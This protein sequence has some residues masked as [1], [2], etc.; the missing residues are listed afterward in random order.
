[1]KFHLWFTDFPPLTHTAARRLLSRGEFSLDIP[2]FMSTG[3][4]KARFLLKSGE[5]I[6]LSLQEASEE[7][8]ASCSACRSREEILCTHA[9]GAVLALREHLTKNGPLQS[10]PERSPG[11]ISRSPS[12]RDPDPTALL[13]CTELVLAGSKHSPAF[14]VLTS[15]KKPLDP[16]SFR[17]LESIERTRPGTLSKTASLFIA[18]FEPC[19]ITEK[20]GRTIPAYRP[21]KT[22][23]GKI[24]QYFALPGIRIYSTKSHTP[25][26][27]GFLAN[28]PL[29]ELTARWVNEP[30]GD[31]FLEGWLALGTE[32][33]FLKDTLWID[34]DGCSA[35]CGQGT[36]LFFEQDTRLPSSLKRLMDR[37]MEGRPLSAGEW[38]PLLDPLGGN[39]DH[40]RFLSF[41]PSSAS[42][43]FGA[44]QAWTPVVVVRGCQDG[45]L[46]LIPAM[47]FSGQ[48][49]VP[50]FGAARHRLGDYLRKPTDSLAPTLFLI[51]RD[52]EREL[53]FRSL[54]EKI[55]RMSSTEESIQ[56]DKG[57]AGLVLDQLLPALESSGFGID[58]SG[59]FDGSIL[60]GPVAVRLSVSALSRELLRVQGTLDT[61]GGRF[62]L[63]P[64]PRKES[65]S[66]PEDSLISVNS[67]KS[68]YLEG[69]A[70]E[71]FREIHQ[72]FS[73]E[74]DGSASVSRFY[75]AMLK[76][77]R[78][79]LPIIP[80][81]GLEGKLAPFVPV[82]IPPALFDRLSTVFGATLRPYQREALSFLHSLW[83]EGL[84]GILAD[85]MGLGKTISVLGFLMLMKMENAFPP[86]TRPPLIALPASLLYNW[87]HEAN[88]FC[89][90]VRLHVHA[91]TGRM[92]RLS[93]SENSDLILTTYGTLRNDPHLAE[94]FPFSCLVL[95]E[96]HLVKNPDSRTHQ[97]IRSLPALR[98]IA[99]TG[100]PVENRISD[101]WGIFDITMPNFLGSRL[102]FEKRFFREN[103]GESERDSRISLLR[104]LVSPLILRRTKEMV[105][106]DL[107]PKVEVDIW[108]DPSPEERS[109]YARIKSRGTE[110]ILSSKHLEGPLRMAYLTLLL[111]LRQLACHPDLLPPEIRGDLNHSSKFDLVLDKITE[112][113]EE[114][115]KILLFSQFTSILDLFEN[116]LPA[117]GISSVRLDG[118]TPLPERQK[119]VA[120]FQSDSP[121]SPS[122]F[123]ASL[124]AGG[125][126][127]TL[128]RADYVFH[129]DP[130]WNPQV[131][132]QASDRSHRLGQDRKVFVY[133]FLVRGTVEE[134][135]QSLKESK[136]EIFNLLMNDSPGETP[137]E[138]GIGGLSI[139]DMKGLLDFAPDT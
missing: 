13:P 53:Y 5:I 87:V 136:K 19:R 98:R 48:I 32:K 129:Y 22:R 50:L 91:G 111:R 94:G 78:P 122:V 117:L 24:L 6:H 109:L 60:P 28:P 90:G 31:L 138:K 30:G 68:I 126:G 4:L 76:S 114:G 116:A 45:S 35:V 79:D 49:S 17:L 18:S 104:R 130:W 93:R 137:G 57:K 23:D 58:R 85:E 47:K 105:L 51:G 69:M 40:A 8:L 77:L 119:R 75:V 103:E 1:M 33:R 39:A 108:V 41:S 88:R 131:E 110:E 107:P 66:A 27:V 113:T 29:P 9:A 102:L 89:P 127:L 59:L 43:V 106:P 101:L 100:T 81:E 134:R 3:T 132:A 2:G 16:E 67:G 97:V 56:V 26:R 21:I 120:A 73:L 125:V 96:A 86:D 34:F 80:G 82:P 37:A 95:D 62:P 61:G 15:Q 12:R 10:V 74:K 128:T 65:S 112:G 46:A 36:L 14:V 139:E 55:T 83:Q 25:Y 118:S 7:I 52:R 44:R 20:N 124:K 121:G 64:A 135:V 133:R 123:L 84:S 71:H 99:M 115:H 92:E 11:Q 70:R 54:F 38:P 72:L 42:P 63:P